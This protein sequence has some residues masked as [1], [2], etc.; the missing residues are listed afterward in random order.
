MGMKGVE[1]FVGKVEWPDTGRA[2]GNLAGC[3][4]CGMCIKDMAFLPHFTHD[5]DD[6]DDDGG[7]GDWTVKREKRDIGGQVGVG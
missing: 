3:A 4:I 7:G 6:D 2:K 1:T 5:D